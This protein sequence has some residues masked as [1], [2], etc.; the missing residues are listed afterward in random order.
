MAFV[1]CIDQGYIQPP[2]AAGV[3]NPTQKGEK[4]LR[5]DARGNGG[6]LHVG[7]CVDAVLLSRKFSS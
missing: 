5:G 4:G 3:V 6:F 7:L 1:K 2:C